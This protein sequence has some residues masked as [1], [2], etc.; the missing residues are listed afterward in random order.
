MKD[1]EELAIKLVGDNNFSNVDINCDNGK[2]IIFTE[3][4]SNIKLGKINCNELQVYGYKTDI[5]LTGL[6]LKPG[7]VINILDLS[8]RTCAKISKLVGK[9]LT[10]YKL[11]LN[12]SIVGNI[13]T[14]IGFTTPNTYVQLI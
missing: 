12:S 3:N 5:L 8:S 13:L 14:D 10:I 4:P 7:S 6:S 11:K 1:S 9:K 2:L